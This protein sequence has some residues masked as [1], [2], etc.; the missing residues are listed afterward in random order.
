M[1]ELTPTLKEA[2]QAGALNPLYKIVLT[3]GESSYTYEED[4]ILPSEH[5]EGM[6]SHRAKIV[7]DNNNHE[8]DDKN[9]KGYDAVISYGVVTGADKEYSPTSPLAVIDQQFDS[10]P[11]KLSCTLELEGM[12]NLM[13]QDEASEVYE[14]DE[15]DTKT[16]KTLVNAIVGATLAPFTHCHAF[17][18]V[19]DDGYDTL[20]DTYK[21]KDSLRIYS[22]N[23]R[24]AILRRVLDFTANVPRFEADG[25]IHI[26]K[27]VTTGTNY[28]SEYSLEK[29]SH[30][31]LS[32]AYRESLTFP[33]RV[34]VQS[35]PGD[36]PQYSG[37]AQVDGYDSLPAKVK[38]THHVQL[39]LESNNQADDIAEALIAK[40]EMGAARG[41]AE[42]RINVGAEVFD[43]V[44][45]TDSRQGD[46][47]TGNLGYI[48]RRFG[49]DKW[50]MTF[51]FGNWLEYLRYK[52][53]LKEL[54]TY[55]DAGQYFSRLNVKHL[56]AENLL[57]K[58]MGF[59]WIDPDN[60]I[61]LSKIGDNLD[62]LPDGEQ[63]A[64]VS[65]WNLSFDEDPESPT[66]Q[67][68]VLKMDEYTVYQPGYNPSEKRRTFT[69][70]PTTPYDIGDLWLDADTVKRCITARASGA[71][72]ASDWMATTLDAIANGDVFSRVKN[73]SLSNEG[74]I[75]LDQVVE[76]DFGL[77]YK[78]DLDAGHLLLS[79]TVKDG[80][81]YEE[82]GVG[83]DADKGIG[84]YG[85]E[86]LM[87]LRTY[88][89]LADYL[90][91]TNVQCYVGT[92]GKIY[93][94]G[95][96]VMLDADGVQINGE[97][98][99]F[100]ESGYIGKI[101]VHETTHCLTLSPPTGYYVESL[102]SGIRPYSDDYQYLGTP[103]KQWK[104]GYFKSRLKIP[105]GVDCYD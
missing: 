90:A 47:R 42:I 60:T 55:T 30:T 70:T 9:L 22:G 95:G 15:D 105:V 84:I 76:G 81:W 58:N 37:E 54:E 85:G 66:Y 14:P 24:L 93:A 28:D 26:L 69:S 83:I 51:G 20:A 36:D 72:Q 74:L 38:K 19:W 44:K 46:T 59:V 56:Y 43:W 67:M 31:F 5:D 41:Q 45:V 29:G 3:K 48:H 35:Q 57:A 102:G 88:P 96:N 16:V 92:D 64:R 6:Y 99:R 94:G 80:A 2:Q 4:R 77:I 86:G 104:G 100:V 39:R 27:P 11:N 79:K 87:G 75:L 68:W 32:K 63:Y 103:S 61:D 98:L 33:N 1:R 73:M 53:I 89:T 8:L 97:Y 10:T 7:L 65:T 82:S 71:Y 18:V 49:K 78:T 50:I 52:N 91:N 62:N 12:P 23:S 34:V 21:A 13:A 17:E 40:A 101:Y 25:K